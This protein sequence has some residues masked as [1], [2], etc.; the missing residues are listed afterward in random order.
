LK[1][2]VRTCEKSFIFKDFHPGFSFYKF[3]R[4]AFLGEVFF[5]TNRLDLKVKI[6]NY[7]I[8][9]LPDRKNS[10][11]QH[12]LQKCPFFKFLPFS[13]Q[14]TRNEKDQGPKN[15]GLTTND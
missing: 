6:K 8:F 13:S 10:K 14:I 9:S 5:Y 4:K 15:L 12:C 3:H 2:Y 7:V 1:I 11:K